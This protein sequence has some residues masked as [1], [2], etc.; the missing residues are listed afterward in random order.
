MNQA[1]DPRRVVRQDYFDIQAELPR[2]PEG[3][4]PHES[5]TR[6]NP[7]AVHRKTGELYHIQDGRWVLGDRK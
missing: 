3:A 2:L 5:C 4:M 1:Y 6:E 7:I